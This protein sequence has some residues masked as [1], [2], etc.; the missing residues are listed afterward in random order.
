MNLYYFTMQE[1]TKKPLYTIADSH[2]EALKKIREVYK[3]KEIY[4]IAQMGE[5]IE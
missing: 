5:V 2:E 4:N 3:E 1:D